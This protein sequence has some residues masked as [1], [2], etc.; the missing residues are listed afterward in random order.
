MC[1]LVA[2]FDGFGGDDLFC[3]MSQVVQARLLKG[4]RVA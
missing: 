1:F 2:K 4:P 3:C